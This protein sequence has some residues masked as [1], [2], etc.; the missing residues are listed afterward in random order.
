MK[1]FLADDTQSPLLFSSCGRLCVHT[2]SA[3]ADTL[4]RHRCGHWTTMSRAHNC[5]HLVHV[6]LVDK[7]DIVRSAKKEKGESMGKGRDDA[8]SIH[9]SVGCIHVSYCNCSFFFEHCHTLCAACCRRYCGVAHLCLHGGVRLVDIN[10]CL[11]WL[12][13]VNL[14]TT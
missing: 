12:D 14:E 9:V 5:F 7:Y 2:S 4:W 6:Q 11:R 10:S 3:T 8:A 1:R 13:A